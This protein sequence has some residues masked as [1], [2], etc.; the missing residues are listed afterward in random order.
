M[1]AKSRKYRI[2]G[3][4]LVTADIA[5]TAPAWMDE[6]HIQ[7]LVH[8]IARIGNFPVVGDRAGESM[9]RAFEHRTKRRLIP[10][11]TL[12]DPNAHLPDSA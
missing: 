9:Q 7:L 8:P 12:K 2:P 3:G 5:A 11:L 1:M 4:T 6:L 10:H